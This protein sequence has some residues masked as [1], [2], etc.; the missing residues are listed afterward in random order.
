MSK[1]LLIS[2][3][4]EELLEYK[5]NSNDSELIR[6]DMECLI[7]KLKLFNIKIN[8]TKEKEEEEK[9]KPI[10]RGF[11]DIAKYN[12]KA[13]YSSSDSEDI[14][15]NI[16]NMN[17][18]NIKLNNDK[19]A[20]FINENALDNLIISDIIIKRKYLNNKEYLSKYN[21]LIVQVKN[22]TNDTE[23]GFYKI[24]NG[25]AIKID[26]YG[27]SKCQRRKN[28]IKNNMITPNY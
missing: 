7:K 1:N 19:E 22:S 26:K 23:N 21:N 11:E 27:Q 14:N 24:I 9:T 8:T 13:D 17:I 4:M 18:N 12:Y 16:K 6:L 15:N 10:F 3:L 25:N 28:K 5:N 2:E 20:K